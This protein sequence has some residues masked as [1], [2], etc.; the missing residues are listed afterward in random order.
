MPT[1]FGDIVD[2]QRKE[3]V[4]YLILARAASER[5]E[6]GEA[7]YLAGQ[8]ARHLEAVRQQ[9]IEMRREPGRPAAKQMLRRGPS[10]REPVPSA[11]ARLPVVLR[12]V[13]YI[14]ETIRR[15]VTKKGL[16][17]TK[18]MSRA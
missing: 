3:S 17:P 11:A 1:D 8:S 5:G 2:Y 12:C 9:K 6:L 10:G 13:K 4:K 16:P 15:A 7:E 18:R 14:V